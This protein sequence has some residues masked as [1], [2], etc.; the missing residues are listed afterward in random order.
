MN[1]AER[2]FTERAN[3][4]ARNKIMKSPAVTAAR[5]DIIKLLAAFFQNDQ[6]K[7][8]AWLSTPNLNIGG[9]SPAGLIASGR[10]DKLLKFM[11]TQ[12]S[13]SGFD[14]EKILSEEAF[15]QESST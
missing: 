8:R 2:R 5:S 15:A 10:H 12:L 9:S 13:D 1:R 11:K 7:I 6:T 3:K 14:V 4:K